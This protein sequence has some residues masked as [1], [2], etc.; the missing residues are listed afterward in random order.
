MTLACTLAMTRK[1]SPHW[2]SIPVSAVGPCFPLVVSPLAANCDEGKQK[3]QAIIDLFYG[4]VAL[5]TDLSD[6]RIASQ[7]HQ[8]VLHTGG[9]TATYL[10]GD[11]KLTR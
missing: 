7:L 10:K 8:V 3:M 2:S 4:S 5:T 1:P 9:R 11:L 6:A